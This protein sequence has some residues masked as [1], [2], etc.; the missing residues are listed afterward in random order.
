LLSEVIDTFVETIPRMLEELH[1]AHERTDAAALGSAAHNLKG[2]ASN[3]CA[4][5]IRQT[6]MQLEED[7]RRN[8]LDHAGQLLSTLQGQVEA[9]CAYVHTLQRE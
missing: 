5:S 7:A 8:N 9:L 4:E 3:V 2:S 1:A 6:A